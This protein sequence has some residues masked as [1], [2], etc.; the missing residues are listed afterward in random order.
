MTLHLYIYNYAYFEIIWIHYF[1]LYDTVG[2]SQRRCDYSETLSRV[3]PIGVP[4]LLAWC[5]LCLQGPASPLR[6]VPGV[7]DEEGMV[8]DTV[9]FIIMCRSRGRIQDFDLG[10]GGEG[11]KIIT[12]GVQG[13]FK[14]PWKLWVFLCS[15]V[16]SEPYF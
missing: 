8:P 9:I 14:G 11:Q 12:A 3:L 13:P 6:D 7:G 15:L 4:V 2:R 10:G 1:L 5:H 16:L